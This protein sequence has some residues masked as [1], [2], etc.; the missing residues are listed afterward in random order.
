MEGLMLIYV[1][2]L[3]IVFTFILVPAYL[4]F[5]S[6]IYGDFYFKNIEGRKVLL[7]SKEK[8]MIMYIKIIVIL[9]EC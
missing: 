8:S 3:F 5:S 4:V 9:L 7:N 2:V 1:L 6:E